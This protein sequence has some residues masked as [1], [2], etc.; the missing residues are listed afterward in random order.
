M[1]SLYEQTLWVAY[2]FKNGILMIENKYVMQV[3]EIG[4]IMK[5]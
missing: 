4:L 2:Y 5:A 1:F 3:Y